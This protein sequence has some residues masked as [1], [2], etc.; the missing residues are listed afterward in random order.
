MKTD[1]L[2]ADHPSALDHAADVLLHGG[3]VVFPTDTVYG[4]AALPSNAEYV[5]RLFI[6]KGRNSA[7]AIAVLIAGAVELEQ[8]AKDPNPTA[9]RLAERFWPG[10]LTLIVSRHPSLPD[11]LSPLPTIGVRIPDHPVALALLR[12][13]GPL[14]VT[15]ANLSGQ[16]NTSTA[17]EVMKQLDGRVHLVIDGG[18]TPGGVPSTVV[19][20]TGKEPLIL[21]EGP[22]TEEHIRAAL[23]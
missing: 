13:T 4:L 5:E 8:V 19:D 1:L 12:K 21:R 18:R 11:V 2:K 22:I 10:P 9:R 15:S 7:R 23:A 16:D 3:T 20:C 17:Q 14:A 6:I